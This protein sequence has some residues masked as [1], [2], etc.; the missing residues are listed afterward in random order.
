MTVDIELLQKAFGKL[1]EACKLIVDFAF[2]VWE[3]I[4]ETVRKLIKHK[5]Y[6]KPRPIYGYVKHRVMKSQVLNRKPM[7]I[8][9][10]TTC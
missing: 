4:K 10:R 6:C 1:Y 2:Q 5:L 8:R 9:A 7:L 3:Q